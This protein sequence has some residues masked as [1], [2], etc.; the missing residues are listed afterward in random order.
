MIKDI[1]VEFDRL[2]ER[3]ETLLIDSR[4]PQTRERE[5]ELEIELDRVECRMDEI[6]SIVEYGRRTK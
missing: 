2:L 1:T 3:H 5:L 6:C 4:Q